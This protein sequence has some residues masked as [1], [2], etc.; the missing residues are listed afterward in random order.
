MQKPTV[1]SHFV[2]NFNESKHPIL[3]VF[4]PTVQFLM[5]P[6]EARESLCILKSV[7]PP[8]SFVP[9]HSHED[10]ECFYMISGYQEALI[11]AQGEL[12]WI[13]C[14]PGDSIQVPGRA[15]HAFRNGLSE[16]A[17]SLCATT[18]KLGRFFEEIGRPLLPG[19]QPAAPTPDELEKFVQ[20]AVRYGYWLATPDENAAAGVPNSQQSSS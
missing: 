20:I 7:I 11:E 3:E 12:S 16:P 4:G 14:N 17:I 5:T 1:R 18:A 15:K 9:L 10:V 19:Q 6:A 13:G 8:G 2:Y